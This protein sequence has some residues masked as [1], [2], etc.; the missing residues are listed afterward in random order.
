VSE[1]VKAVQ[2]RQHKTGHLMVLE[3][4]CRTRRLLAC[5]AL[6]NLTACSGGVGDSAT[7]ANPAA[8]APAV[9]I[10]ADVAK[11]IINQVVTISWSSTGTTTCTLS[12][13]LTGVVTTSGDRTVQKPAAGTI[14]VEIVCSGGGGTAAGKVTVEV[15]GSTTY[16]VSTTGVPAYPSGYLVATTDSRD[17]QTDP[18]KLI[19]P[20]VAYPQSWMGSRPLPQ[21]VGAPLSAEIGRAMMVKDI[22][23]DNNP[24]FVLKG[25]APDA[26]N[27]CDHGA[28]AL[29]GEID[30]TVQRLKQLGVQ[31]VSIP[32]WHWAKIN[33][34][35]SYA[36]T[37]ADTTFGSLSDANLAYY[38]GAAHAVGIKVIMTNQ[39]QGFIDAQGNNIATPPSNLETF[40]KWLAVY[41]SFMTTQAPQFQS[42]GIDIWELG[43]GFCLW[44]DT[45]DGSQAAYDLFALKY[46]EIA[47][48]IKGSFRGKLM[49][50]GVP[51]LK[52]HPEVLDQVDIIQTSFY[53]RTTITQSQSD[54]ISVASYKNLVDHGIKYWASTGKTV[55]VASY[56]QSRADALTNPGY[57]EEA[58][59]TGDI[60]PNGDLAAIDNTICLQRKTKPDF[61]IQAI[62][63][64]A[65]MEMIK[66]T[67]VTNL[68]VVIY[69][70]W[71]TD[72]LL[73][74]TAFPNIATSIRNKPAEGVVR[75]WFA[76]P[77]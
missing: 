43:C 22:M 55:M 9:I 68:I 16:S 74:Q 59:C 66:D 49:I 8:P 28:G 21:V 41:K 48:I 31:Y 42:L 70:Y 47:K 26:P 72:T 33:S 12:G 6:C 77:R 20:T 69:D 11:A 4:F 39:I 32:Q 45:G 54:A 75:Q 1:I 44:H 35:G 56:I 53:P 34:D 13:D 73:P 7:T 51:W 46:S 57:L 14:N 2:R 17:I 5:V 24:A 29:K 36:F 23:L 76:L 71:A 37:S 60:P 52:D 61:S 30:K 19:L 25:Q 64:E 3:G 62:V 67:G 10:R 50:S 65:H 58:V 18:C 27:G 15:T 40:R 63:H 38:V